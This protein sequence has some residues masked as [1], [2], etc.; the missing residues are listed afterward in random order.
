[1]QVSLVVLVVF[2]VSLAR[3]A[4]RVVLL[5]KFSATWCPHC[6]SAA[7]VLDDL[8]QDYPNRFI[9]LE[10]FSLTVRGGRY[11]TPW[12]QSRTFGFYNVASYPTAWF[13]GV[14]NQ[15]DPNNIYGSSLNQINNRLMVPTDLVIDVSA[16]RTGERSYDVTTSVG[17]EASGIAKV[18]RLYLV[19]ALDHF[20]VYDDGTTIPRNTLKQVLDGGFDV[21]LTPG[22]TQNITRSITFDDDSWNNFE[23]IRLVAWAQA[24][25]AAGPAEV[26]NAAQLSFFQLLAGDFDSDGVVTSGDLNVWKGAFGV[27]GTG[28]ANGDHDGDTDGTD[29]LAWQRTLGNSG[30]PAVGV[31]MVPEPSAFVVLCVLA[32]IGITKGRRASS[33]VLGER[34][35][36][37]FG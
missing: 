27:E 4:E 3:G 14:T 12:G 34:S 5:E 11:H 23:D 25:N 35:S 26:Y 30:P 18:V 20:G 29:F 16:R 33:A 36:K 2:H 7:P 24:P 31:S 9:P 1:M 13:D 8:L 15:V 10:I 37:R 19:E 6:M 21:T 17:I 28:Y 22:Q 32:G